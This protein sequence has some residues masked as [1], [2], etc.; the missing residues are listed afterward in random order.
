MICGPKVMSGNFL[1]LNTFDI[2]RQIDH[3]FARN[4]ADQLSKHASLECQEHREHAAEKRRVK[5]EKEAHA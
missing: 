5:E 2:L 4:L 1:D 3:M